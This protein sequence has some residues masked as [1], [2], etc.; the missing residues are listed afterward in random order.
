M[1]YFALNIAYLLTRQPFTFRAG[2]RHF[3]QLLA[4]YISGN[5]AHFRAPLLPERVQMM[6]KA[7]GF[8]PFGTVQTHNF[9]AR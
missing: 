2:T 8:T 1:A 7:L 5:I 4:K 9:L 6:V 3:R